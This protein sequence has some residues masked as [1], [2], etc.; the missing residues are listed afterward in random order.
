MLCRYHSVNNWLFRGEIILS[1]RASTL[2]CQMLWFCLYVFKT[3]SVEKELCDFLP[4]PRMK[5]QCSWRDKIVDMFD[6]NN[7]M[8]EVHIGT[9]QGWWR[10]P[11]Y[12]FNWLMKLS[13][14]NIT[15]WWLFV[16]GRRGEK[17]AAATATSRAEAEAG[18]RSERTKKEEQRKIQ[19]ELDMEFSSLSVVARLRLADAALM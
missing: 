2:A 9:G 11:T 16:R 13:R 1:F 17:V 18:C 5:Y 12:L 10:V 19:R 15:T 6:G 8:V 3:N 14:R 4:M 7:R